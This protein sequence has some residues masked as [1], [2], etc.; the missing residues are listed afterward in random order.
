MASSISYSTTKTS[1]ANCQR[2]LAAYYSKGENATKIAPYTEGEN[3]VLIK[4]LIA[5]MEE[6]A[7]GS[8]AKSLN[9]P[10]A[11]LLFAGSLFWA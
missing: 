2:Y 5:Q 4:R 9:G 7:A 1:V 8:E 3:P 10:E 6:I 11:Q